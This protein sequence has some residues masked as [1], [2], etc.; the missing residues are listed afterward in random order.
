MQIRPEIL[1]RGEILIHFIIYWV[2]CAS[3]KLQL[4]WI[5]VNFIWNEYLLTI[6]AD[7]VKIICRLIFAYSELSPV[8]KCIAF[9]AHYFQVCKYHDHIYRR[10][11][12]RSSHL[13]SSY[14][15][16]HAIHQYIYNC[17]IWILKKGKYGK[18]IILL[19]WPRFVATN[20]SILAS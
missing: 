16:N 4:V 20:S 11:D 12:Q 8:H 5:F 1:K 14:N 15:A 10:L 17:N 13:I 9:Q 2:F 7:S 6:D 18:D 19:V 3:T